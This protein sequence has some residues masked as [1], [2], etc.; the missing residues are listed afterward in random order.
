[1]PFTRNAMLNFHLY[2]V[3]KDCTFG[4][5]VFIKH[6]FQHSLELYSIH[7]VSCSKPVSISVGHLTKGKSISKKSYIIL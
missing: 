4:V 3:L 2:V 1:M 6:L 5:M 7:F